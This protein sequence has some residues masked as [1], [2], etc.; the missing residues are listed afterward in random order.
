M[1]Y[2]AD[3][4]GLRA[5]AIVP[6]LLFHAGFEVFSGGYVGVDV[7]FV[8]S[9]FL[10]TSII[11]KE[12]QEDRFTISNFYE[13]RARR[14]LPSYILV[15]CSVIALGYYLL[16][17]SEYV[18][19]VYAM[20]ASLGFVSNI[21]FWRNSGYFS[22]ESEYS[23]FLHTWSLSIEEQFYLF[24]PFLIIF[25]LRKGNAKLLLYS[26]LLISI[27]SLLISEYGKT[28]SMSASF[29]LLPTRAWELLFGSILVFV[30]NRYILRGKWGGG[31]SIIFI[32]FILYPIFSYT[33]KTSFPGY[34][35]LLPVLG[36]CGL[37][38]IG[39]Y[40]NNIITKFIGNSAFVW[41]GKISYS[42]YLWHW[43]IIVYMKNVYGDVLSFEHKI[44]AI[45]FSVLLAWVSTNT[46]ERIFLTKKVAVTKQSM[47]KYSAAGICMVAILAFPIIYSSGLPYRYSPE[48]LAAEASLEDFSSYRGK[49]HIEKNY[50]IKYIDK[51]VFG[52]LA[53]EPTYAFWGDSH[54]VELS[55]AL[56]V[57][58]QN[59]GVSGIHISYSSC[60]PSQGFSW[61][62]RPYCDEH[63]KDILEEL[64]SDSSINL[65]FL[66]ARYNSYQRTDRM[67]GDMMDGFEVTV[68]ALRHAGKDVVIIYPIPKANGLAP[69]DVARVIDRKGSEYFISQD[70]YEGRNDFVL[71]RLDIIRSESGAAAIYPANILCHDDRKCKFYIDGRVTHFD[72][73]HLSLFGA[74]LLVPMMSELLLGRK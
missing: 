20:L 29:Y 14:I 59:K 15:V 30:Q 73:D 58:M 42:L 48:V 70:E 63:N 31:L 27:I 3:I 36:A 25:M 45:V 19:T 38:W 26:I 71:N 12:V 28:L 60:P 67:L 64:V 50:T 17:P 34:N 53:S 21:Y 54:A 18:G 23:P 52:D 51:C 2:R 4:D 69:I 33:E 11:M 43:P 61:V 74:S 9:G 49:C 40:S 22:P 32:A 55:D 10:I 44:Y 56:G 16:L 41:V 8:I 1:K 7:F 13:R 47:F 6:V 24:F 65:V 72:D 39:G 46:I 62:S 35:A 57:E 66:I 37:I 68:K 5:I